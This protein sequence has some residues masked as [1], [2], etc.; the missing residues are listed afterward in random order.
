MLSAP[1]QFPDF[2]EQWGNIQNQTSVTGFPVVP[3]SGGGFPSGEGLSWENLQNQTSG[4]VPG[5]SGDLPTFGGGFPGAEGISWEN[6]QNQTSGGAPAPPG[7]LPTYPGGLSWENLQN[8]T[9]G[10]LSGAS[11]N[12]PEFSSGLPG[13]E[14]GSGFPALPGTSGD[15]PQLSGTPSWE[16]IQNQTSGGMSGA[17]DN[18]PDFSGGIPGQSGGT[19]FPGGE[20]WD[21]IRNQTGSRVELPGGGNIPGG[22]G[23]GNFGDMQNQ[24]IPGMNVGTGYFEQLQNQ[25][26]PG[27]VNQGCPS[28]L[29]GENN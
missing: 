25:T 1:Q 18:I 16:N 3:P 11:G 26:L 17:S 19:G 12:I 7:D 15:I 2:G 22:D 6:I 4:G 8:Q 24:T 20:Q 29:G 21:T 27:N 14:G 13:Q 5:A 10:G 9:S 28:G 23:F